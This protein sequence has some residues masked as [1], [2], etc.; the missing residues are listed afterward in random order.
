MD[1]K[2][3]DHIEN[4]IREAADNSSQFPF[5]EQS[6]NKMETLLDKGNKRRAFA[7]WWFAL[8]A[9]MIAGASMYWVHDHTTAST[10]ASRPVVNDVIPGSTSGSFMNTVSANRKPVAADITRDDATI[11]N[12]THRYT[13]PDDPSYR[14]AT[15]G[16]TRARVKQMAQTGD[17]IDAV[18]PSA[19]I[20][21]KVND[22]N[23]FATTSTDSINKLSV[24]DILKK[25]SLKK[26]T[27]LTLAKTSD[28]MKNLAASGFYIL[29]MGG[30]D[31]ADVHFLSFNNTTLTPRYGIGIGYQ[32]S[33]RLSVQSGFYAGRKKYIA[34]PADYKAKPGTYYATVDIT[35]V[36][37]NCLVYDIP[38]TMRYDFVQ[39]NQTV[40]YATIGLSSFI[41]KNE[42]YNYNYIDAG[43]SSTASKTYTGNQSLFSILNLSA[44]YEKILNNKFSLLAEPSVSIP[45]AGVGEGSVKLYSTSLMI[46]LKYRFGKK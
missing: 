17:V 7:W 23:E 28:K 8:P 39:H 15:R 33:N 45:L 36:D 35:K 12:N 3:F 41:M 34:G 4:K 2:P 24:K 26:D 1:K 44:G 18:Q 10:V 6:W 40:W 11:I 20:V 43:V 37:A 30:A 21:E 31:A 5:E 25:P 22:K 29:A 16:R 14:L 32:L 38:L 27:I 42:A 19:T 46:G 9:L 13:Q